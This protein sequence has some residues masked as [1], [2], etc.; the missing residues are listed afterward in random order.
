MEK[1][2]NCGKYSIVYEKYYGRKI[3]LMRNCG[4][5]ELSSNRK[6]IENETREVIKEHE[7]L[8]TPVGQL[9]NYK[10]SDQT[11]LIELTN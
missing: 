1:C 9:S 10:I 8:S 4:W 5:S 3:C 11:K 2:P 6:S 7:N